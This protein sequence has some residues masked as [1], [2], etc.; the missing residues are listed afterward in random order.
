VVT[1]GL[2]VL[3]R[4]TVQWLADHG[5]RDLLVLGRSPLPA[6]SPDAAKAEA[7]ER[8]ERAGIRIDYRSLDVADAAGIRQ[9]LDER[10]RAG[11]PPVRGA[12]HAA[13]IVRHRSVGEMTSRDLEELLRVKLIGGWALHEA[14]RDEPV[15]FFVLYSSLAALAAQRGVG[16]PS[17]LSIGWGLWG[18][19]G[20]AAESGDGT[21]PVSPQLV[22]AALERLA[23]GDTAHAVVLAAD[24]PRRAAANEGAAVDPL[25]RELVAAA[26]MRDGGSPAVDPGA[27]ATPEP[28][29]A[30][31]TAPRI[32]ELVPIP[33][34]IPTPAPAPVTPADSS[35][36][37]ISTYIATEVSRVLGLPVHA[38]DLREPLQTQ[39]LD[40]LMA[41]EVRRGVK[42]RFG[43]LIP[44]TKLLR[45]HSVDDLAGEVT[46]GLTPVAG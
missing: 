42:R 3:G 28:A 21:A 6:D 46:K 32:P 23:A 35:H 5:A 29:P 16:G 11:S 9:V 45:G 26:P 31:V 15:D 17:A 41:A 36:E 1:G 37:E 25:L 19:V 22:T 39:G 34:P 24:W 8:W 30:A 44:L 7:V 10:R 20:M 14:L 38:L 18:E 4:L 12:I 13:G 2:G 43:V 33:I 40:S 27:V